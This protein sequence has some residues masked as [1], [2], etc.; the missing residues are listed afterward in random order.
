MRI[1]ENFLSVLHRTHRQTRSEQ[2]LGRVRFGLTAEPFIDGLSK[3]ARHILGPIRSGRRTFFSHKI[4]PLNSLAEFSPVS[5][6]GYNE[7]D[8]SIFAEERSPGGHVGLIAA[9]QNALGQ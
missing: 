1:V 6:C 7:T 8:I 5:F 4:R 2:F 3:P 9:F